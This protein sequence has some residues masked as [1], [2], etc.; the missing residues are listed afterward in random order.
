ML[1][2]VELVEEFVHTVIASGR[3]AESAPVSVVLI[4]TPETGKTSIVLERPSE[5]VLTVTKTTAMG[6]EFL[7]QNNPRA[8]HL[9]LSDMT[10]IGAL[11][12]KTAKS[13]F[14]MLKPMVEEGLGTIA[15][16]GGIRQMKGRQMGLIGCITPSA[17][18]DHRSWW[19]THGLASRL[20]PFN[21]DYSL[22]LTIRIKSAID[23]GQWT[24]WK[25]G[26]SLRMPEL[27]VRVL[28]E[29][30]ETKQIRALADKKAIQFKERGIRLLLQ[31][32]SLAKA[33]AVLRSGKWK[34]VRVTG[35]DVHFL[36]RIYPY[37]DWEVGPIL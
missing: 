22:A 33:H 27:P 18:R 25:P 17:A 14:E 29:K 23:G 7:L 9:L 16:P 12:S 28:L 4:A 35:E 37:V 13:L 3:I 2:G 5:T 36:N 1:M 11:S 8:T 21:Y 30:K 15:D 10:Y 34:N 20:V 19:W 31:F 24:G 26:R 6:L 32:R